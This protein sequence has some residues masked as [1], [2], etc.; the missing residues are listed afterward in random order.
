MY[1]ETSLEH[2]VAGGLVIFIASPNIHVTLV[3][4]TAKGNTGDLGSNIAIFFII[5][6]AS[7]SSVVVNNCRIMDGYAFIGGGLAFWSEQNRVHNK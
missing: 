1:G 7:S 4:V 2:S 5:F 3:N 6:D